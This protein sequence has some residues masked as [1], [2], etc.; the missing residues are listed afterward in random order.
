[1]TIVE[2]QDQLELYLLEVEEKYLESHLGTLETPNDYMFDVKCYCILSHAAFEEFV[3][4]VCVTLLNE[5]CD[6]F[7]SHQQYAYSTL[8]L[9]HFMGAAGEISDDTW[10]DNQRLFDYFRQKLTEIKSDCSK[11]IIEKNHGVGLKYIKKLLIPLGI[12]IPQNP[13][14]Q[15]SLSQL[16]NYRGGYAH[17]SKRKAITLSP[18]DAKKYVT[19][20]YSMMIDIVK[21]VK[22]IRYFSIK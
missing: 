21:R 22:N 12:D 9:L 13:V 20:V 5:T 8:C 18:E 2:A 1:M 7:L 19:D 6:N 16:A 17:T 11:Y 10:A 3:E 4:N 15:N 14:W